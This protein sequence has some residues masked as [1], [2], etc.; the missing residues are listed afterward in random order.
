LHAAVVPSGI[1]ASTVARSNYHRIWARDSL[2]CGLAG[3]ASGD[4]QLID[5]LGASLR[6]LARQVGRTGLLPSNVSADGEGPPSYGGLAGRVDAGAW[7]IIGACHF[8]EARP[9]DEARSI[10]VE[11]IKGCLRLYD[12]WE[13]NERG[14]VNVPMGGCWADEYPIHG[15]TL[16]EE[17]LRVWALRLAAKTLSRPEWS[18]QAQRIQDLIEATYWIDESKDGSDSYHPRAYA[19]AQDKGAPRHWMAALSPGGYQMCF[20]AL[21][22]SLAVFLGFGTRAIRDQVLDSG[23]AIAKERARAL[24]PAFWPPIGPDDSEWD[25]LQALCVHGFRNEVGEYHNGGL[26]P[27]VNGFWGAALCRSGRKDEAAALLEAMS[28]A[29]LASANHSP[30]GFYEFHSATT[31]SPGGTPMCTWS[32]AG[33]VLLAAALEG[34][35]LDTGISQEVH[36]DGR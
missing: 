30:H 18:A 24:V 15:Y 26:W 4:A 32:A 14:L 25:A 23:Q 19:R 11:T 1:L 34:H 5:A 31:G 9:D 12:A 8:L 21:A 3:I 13:L 29:N 6:S 16:T 22:N 35:E 33:E 27:M 20:D 10:F 36:D 17:C 2:I 7:F 28:E